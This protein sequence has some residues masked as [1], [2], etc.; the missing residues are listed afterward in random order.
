MTQN[1][2]GRI[3]GRSVEIKPIAG[4]GRMAHSCFEGEIMGGALCLKGV[5]VCAKEA[6]S[7]RMVQESGGSTAD[8]LGSARN[9]EKSR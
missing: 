5:K 9:L 7:G 4:F 8:R 2:A 3:D 1:Q 6:R